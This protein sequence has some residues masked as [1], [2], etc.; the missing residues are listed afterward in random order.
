MVWEKGVMYKLFLGIVNC[1]FFKRKES[2][3]FCKRKVGTKVENMEGEDL[4]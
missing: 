3:F 2:L 1:L 4:V